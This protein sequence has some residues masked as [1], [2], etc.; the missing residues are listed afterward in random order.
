MTHAARPATRGVGESSPEVMG[1]TNLEW[2]AA[3]CPEA[4]L[5]AIAPR[6]GREGNE[7][8]VCIHHGQCWGYRGTCADGIREYLTA[9]RDT[10]S[11]I[12]P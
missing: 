5:A 6:D 1:M 4:I 8:A 10:W 11:K 3:N 9:E 2:L 7:C 12:R